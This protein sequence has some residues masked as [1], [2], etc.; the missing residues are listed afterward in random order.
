M[1][2]ESALNIGSHEVARR[3]QRL[4]GRHAAATS[5]SSRS[6]DYYSPC[7]T[8]WDLNLGGLATGPPQG[9]R[10]R[11]GAAMTAEGPIRGEQ[12]VSFAVRG[13]GNKTS[14]GKLHACE[15]VV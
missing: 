10:Q 14:R 7:A 3:R 6:S 5:K 1:F 11:R 12:R 8:G 13:E 4:D 9:V 2:T 15:E